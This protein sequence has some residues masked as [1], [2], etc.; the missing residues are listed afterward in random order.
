MLIE[1]DV[2]LCQSLKIILQRAGYFVT[3]TDCVSKAINSIQNGNYYLII[4]DMNMPDTNK[5]L[6]PRVMGR[7]PHLSIVI[8]SDQSA[9][10]VPKDDMQLSVHYLNKPIAPEQLIDCVGTLIGKNNHANHNDVSR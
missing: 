8:L 5:F 10:E 1:D 7:Y 6:L 9:L 3:S 4:A 2:N